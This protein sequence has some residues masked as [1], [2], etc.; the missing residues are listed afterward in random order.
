[1]TEELIPPMATKHPRL[2]ALKR[3]FEYRLGR[4]VSWKSEMGAKQFV[5][6][7]STEDQVCYT[8]QVE[9]RTPVSLI[10]LP[11]QLAEMNADELRKFMDVSLGDLITAALNGLSILPKD[12]ENRKRREASK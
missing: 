11:E 8:I 10:I 4:W 7:L 1:M 6:D 3:H 2:W 12:V 9:G 5:W